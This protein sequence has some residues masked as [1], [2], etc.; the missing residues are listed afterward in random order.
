MLIYSCYDP[1]IEI[2]F[3]RIYVNKHKTGNMMAHAT[4]TNNVNAFCMTLYLA[5]F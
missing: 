5:L 3:L 2:I 4:Y 1:H